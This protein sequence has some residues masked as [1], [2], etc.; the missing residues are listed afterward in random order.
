MKIIIKIRDIV[1]AFIVL[2]GILLF[3]GGV[4]D[5]Y[6]VENAIPLEK[7]SGKNI[8]IGMYVKGTV[9]EYCGVVGNEVD[10]EAFSG[11]SVSY[12][13]YSGD[14]DF[15]T[16]KLSDGKYVTLMAEHSDTKITLKK[17][18]NGIGNSTYIEGIIVPPITELNFEWLQ[19]A[20]GKNSQKEVEK[21]VLSQY[22]I[23]EL[24][25]SKQGIGMFYGLSCIISVALIILFDIIEKIIIQKTVISSFSKKNL[26]YWK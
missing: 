6:H 20:L 2:V 22:A 17:Y 11:E 18:E 15:Y 4:W 5:Y 26:Y 7:L 25:F 3:I 13:S 9:T 19:K 21:L 1:L 14:R 8:G 12:L 10:I 23:K 24:D 16:I